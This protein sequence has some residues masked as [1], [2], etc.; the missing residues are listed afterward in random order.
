[1]TSLA[2]LDPAFSTVWAIEAVNEEIMDAT[3]TPGYGDC[4]RS[5]YTYGHLL[6]HMT[7]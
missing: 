1:M 3:Q 5:R 2:H 6:I 7:P 4:G